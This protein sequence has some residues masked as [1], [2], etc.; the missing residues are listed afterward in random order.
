MKFYPINFFMRQSKKQIYIQD[1]LDAAAG[2]TTM[3]ARKNLFFIAWIHAIGYNRALE[4][5]AW[6]GFSQ[7]C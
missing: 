1:Y 4:R 3:E 6:T 2:S 5:K 7:N